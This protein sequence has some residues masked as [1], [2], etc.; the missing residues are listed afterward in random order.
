MNVQTYDMNK[1]IS[2]TPKAAE[3]FAKQLEKSRGKAVRIS[4]KESGCT[5]YKYVIHPVDKPQENDICITLDNG[6]K[7]FVDPDNVAALQGTVIDYTQEGLNYNLVLN[8]PNV[9]EACGCG[10]SFSV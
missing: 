6:V 7:F 5:G 8:N 4:L 10:E 2:A 9:K 3:H 1:V